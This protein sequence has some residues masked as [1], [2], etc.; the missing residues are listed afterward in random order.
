MADRLFMLEH[1]I[2]SV[3]SPEGCAAILWKKNGEIGSQEFSRAAEALKLTA[4]DLLNF[5]I[6]NGIIEEPRGGAHRDQEGMAER[7]KETVFKT[8][9]EL[10]S[11]NP[12]KLLA[13]RYEQLR[14]IG[15][16]FQKEKGQ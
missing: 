10:S 15:G 11:M 5:R 4:Q 3:I 12:D 8:L 16:L 13:D 6:I 2:F 9:E 1:A 7:I 14:L